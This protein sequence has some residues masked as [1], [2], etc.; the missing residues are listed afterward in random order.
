[1][2]F[3]WSHQTYRVPRVHGEKTTTDGRDCQLNPSKRPP[4]YLKKKTMPMPTMPKTK[5]TECNGNKR[6]SAFPTA[7]TVLPL[8]H[9]LSQTAS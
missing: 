3:H 5:R 1:M 4:E 7:C 8:T 9:E 2:Y 6:T